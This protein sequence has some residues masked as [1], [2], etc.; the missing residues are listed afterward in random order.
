L[1]AVVSVFDCAAFT[2]WGH[3]GQLVVGNSKG[4]NKTLQ[5]NH[6][7]KCNDCIIV[8]RLAINLKAWRLSVCPFVLINDK[9]CPKLL[10]CLPTTY[11]T[12]RSVDL[13]L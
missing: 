2:S 3:C 5:Q 1:R 8:N 4:V 13:Y 6:I 9:Y 11:S 12:P 10:I 7:I